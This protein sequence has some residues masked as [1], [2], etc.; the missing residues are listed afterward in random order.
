MTTLACFE[1][2]DNVIS[3][4]QFARDEPSNKTQYARVKNKSI[5][6]KEARNGE[7]S[8][9]KDVN[10]I[11]RISEYFW[12][13]KKYRDWCLFN[14]GVTTGYRASDLLRIK[15]SDVAVQNID[16]T[17]CV[18]DDVEVRIKEKKT[19]KYRVVKVPKATLNVIRRYLEVSNLGINDWLFPSRKGSSAGSLRS[20]GG[21]SVGKK[22]GIMYKYESDPKQAGDPIDVDSFGE[23]MRK[24]Q[25][26]LQLPYKL[27]THSCRKT[28]G[29]QF[30]MNHCGDA[31]AL[32]WL[33]KNL[34]HSSQAI[35]LHYIGLDDDVD[36]AYL[37]EIDYGIDIHEV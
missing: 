4:V 27:G 17:I 13:N 9:I 2:D 16:G 18:L 10:D 8:P 31:M 1:N 30:M 7:V 12:N 19:G 32:A 22:S 28:F 35:T 29:Y 6:R 11:K 25:K 14:V 36:Q 23:T 3:G 21:I 20:N 34:N 24:V 33:Q 5:V 26:D 37:S 15:V